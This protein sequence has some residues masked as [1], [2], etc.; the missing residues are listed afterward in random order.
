MSGRLIY[1]DRG[2]RISIMARV[3]AQRPDTLQQTGSR[4][5]RKNPLA[6]QGR[7]IHSERTGYYFR[8]GQ[9]QMVIFGETHL[10]RILSTYAAYYNQARTH[11]ALQKDAPSHRAVQRSG[12]II[13]IPILAGLHHH[14]VR[15]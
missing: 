15:I 8:K 5:T 10:R 12:A 7:A 6:D 9:D 1:E 4:P 14:Y 3:N 11:L 13:A 2:T